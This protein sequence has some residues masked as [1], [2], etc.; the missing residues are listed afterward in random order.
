MIIT[1]ELSRQDK[2]SIVRLNNY[3]EKSPKRTQ[4]T[5]QRIYCKINNYVEKDPEEVQ[6]AN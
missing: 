6:S 1:K 4:Q 2:E 5:G 3:V